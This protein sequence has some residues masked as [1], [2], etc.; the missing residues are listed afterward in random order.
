MI[1]KRNKVVMIIFLCMFSLLILSDLEV[2]HA[3]NE[4]TIDYLECY[5]GITE[6]MLI[7]IQE[8]SVNS[9]GDKLFLFFLDIN[10]DS[11]PELILYSGGYSSASVT[12]LDVY[13]IVD[14]N[15]KFLYSDDF[16]VN[17]IK[18][19]KN[20][21]TNDKKYL[22][23]NGRMGW[24]HDYEIEI[25]G[26]TPLFHVNY[27]ENK[28]YIGKEN[29][30]RLDENEITEDEYKKYY[31][32]NEEI[33]I[34]I[35]KHYLEEISVNEIV[36]KLENA[37]N[38]YL[39]ENHKETGTNDNSNKIIE[40]VEKYTYDFDYGTLKNCI[41][42][43]DYEEAKKILTAAKDSHTERWNYI[44]LLKNEMYI[45]YQFKKYMNEDFGSKGWWAKLSTFI[46]GLFYNDEL[47]SYISTK[48]PGKEKYKEMLKQYINDTSNDII[49][50]E[51]AEQIIKSLNSVDGLMDEISVD[52]YDIL[53]YMLSAGKNSKEEIDKAVYEF[54]NTNY[55][56]FYREG[57]RYVLHNNLSNALKVAGYGVDILTTS[58]STYQELQFVSANMGAFERYEDMLYN[59]QNI[60][61]KETKDY[62]APKELRQAARELGE[63]LK[64]NYSTIITNFIN[65][66][67]VT[68]TSG[69]IDIT[70]IINNAALSKIL[71]GID[72]GSIVGNI[73]FD[74]S[75]LVKGVS[76]VEGYAYLGEIYS[77]V[78]ENDRSEFLISKTEQNAKKFKEDYETLWRIR[79]LGEQS[80]IEMSDFSGS[81]LK[82]DKEILKNWISY[83]EKE[84]FCK[85]NI[86]MIEGF[87]FVTDAENNLFEVSK[88]EGIIAR[89]YYFMSQKNE[90]ETTIKVVQLSG[91]EIYNL[92]SSL[93]SDKVFDYDIKINEDFTS[94]INISDLDKLSYSVLGLTIDQWKDKS[95]M[96]ILNNNECILRMGDYGLGVPYS[97]VENIEEGE[98][99]K[100]ITGQ[101]GVN[102]EGSIEVYPFKVVMTKVNTSYYIDEMNFIFPKINSVKSVEEVKDRL[103]SIYPE[104]KV[105]IERP[106]DDAY[107][108]SV[109]YPSGGGSESYMKISYIIKY[110]TETD[111]VYEY[112]LYEDE[113]L[114]YDL[115][116]GK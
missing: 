53:Y 38:V 76:Y 71:L 110:I 15:A 25:D 92:L 60:R 101:A 82:E 58:F 17:S 102:K 7:K 86:D 75:S 5:K 91:D 64:G 68:T 8:N 42:N 74:M 39:N 78:L 96:E 104:G 48:S 32:E 22:C 90:G 13:S 62:I 19:Y 70:N 20:K 56:Y 46:S 113:P 116:T 99:S 97:K 16:S 47:K 63:E 51:Y 50:L 87:K 72:I 9:T 18:L 69:V 1:I 49:C 14:N 26:L 57:R 33:P 80:Y 34:N 55:E 89:L 6:D 4:K 41:D 31:D 94:T 85:D 65:E 81:W 115:E 54:V 112:N 37:N 93:I 77:V 95:T 61:D 23:S 21:I 3:E 43:G 111:E 66:I 11:I 36:N 100:I 84:N 108:F 67:A 103:E 27:N 59:I 45:A 106:T 107:N 79:L 88:L 105:D 44:G 52:S 73:L 98:K 2:A 83:E 30:V 10:F 24:V 109:S 28:Y 40:Q 29:E 12:K 35:E 114:I